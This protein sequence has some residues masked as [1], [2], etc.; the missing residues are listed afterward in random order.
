MKIEEFEEFMKQYDKKDYGICPPPIS[1]EDSMKILIEHLL[2][3]DWYVTLPL[4]REQ[5]YTEAVCDIIRSYPEKI[6]L[7][8]WFKKLIGR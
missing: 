1:A 2:G 4:G 3:K 6:S 8:Q 7:K 5:V